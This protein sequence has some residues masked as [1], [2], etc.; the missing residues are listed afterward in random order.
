MTVVIAGLDTQRLA[1]VAWMAILAFF[2][3]GIIV[4]LILAFLDQKR[5]NNK[6]LPDFVGPHGE[7]EGLPEVEVPQEA[8]TVFQLE[9]FDPHPEGDAEA[10]SFL[11]DLQALEDTAPTTEKKRRFGLRK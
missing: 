8:S 2:I 4:L 5:Y 6:A 1:G 7:E 11:K 9:D 3:L 10:E